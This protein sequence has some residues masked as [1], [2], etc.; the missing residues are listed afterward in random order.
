VVKGEDGHDTYIV[1]D[2]SLEL[3]EDAAEGTDLVKSK[4][5]WVLG[6]NFENL[7]LIG[8]AHVDGK[9]NDLANTINGNSGANILSGL[10]GSDTL[11]G[12]LGNDVLRGGAGSDQLEGGNGDD[13]LRGQKGNDNLDG[14]NGDDLL[15]GNAGNDIL[16]GGAGDDILIGGAG[17]DKLYGKADDDVFLFRKAAHS[18]DSS[19]ADKIMDF[20]Q[21]EDVIDLTALIPGTL[22]FVGSGAFGGT[23]QG[24][25]RVTT[26]GSNS[27][28]RV[29]VDG[30]GSADMR[31]VVVDLTSMDELDFLL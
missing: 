24:E 28:V 8:S 13:I 3:L 7:K 17:K 18:P 10:G 11:S 15:V 5:G 31:I 23:G 14:E 27:L 19:D 6:D 1:D 16:T 21:G 4:V 20:S 29:D 2:A 22:N 9:G 12:G 26:S 30:D 25:V